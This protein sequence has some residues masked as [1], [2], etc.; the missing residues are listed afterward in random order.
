ME[1]SGSYE[2]LGSCEIAGVPLRKLK[3]RRT[4]II[5]Y[6]AQVEGPLVNG[7][8]CLATEAHDHDGLPHTLEHLIFLGSEDYPYKGV[9]DQL[10]NRCLASGT[11][12]WTD[13]DHTVYTMTNAGSEGF[14][15]LMPVYLEHILYPTLTDSGFITEVHHINGEGEDA[16]V[17]YCEMQAR[18]N[19]AEERTLFHLLQAMY[20][21][22]CGYKSETGGRL[23]NLRTSCSNERV[24]AYHKQYYRPDNLALIITGQLEPDD[25]FVALAPFE[26]KVLHKGPLPPMERPWQSPV[27]PLLSSVCEV[28]PFPSD[29]ER[30]G[31]VIMAWRGP[32]A[33]DRYLY[34]AIVSLVEY[35]HSTSVAPLQQELVYISEPYCSEMELLLQ[36]NAEVCLGLEFHGVPLQMLPQIKDK[37][38][39]I[40]SSIA[41]GKIP[42]DMDRLR[43]ILVKQIRGFLNKMEEDPH[44]FVAFQAIGD[45]LFGQTAQDLVAYIDQTT[46]FRKLMGEPESFWLNLLTHYFIKSPYVAIL[47]TPSTSLA[48][49]MAQEEKDRITKQKEWLGE[50]GLAQKKGELEEAVRQ[51]EV[52]PPV[53][54]V[55]SFPVPGIESIRFHPLLAH[56][57]CS[58]TDATLSQ[59]LPV[60]HLPFFFEVHHIHSSLVKLTAV[61][62]TLAVPTE[63][64]PYIPLYLEL[65]FDSSVQRSGVI[66]SHEIRVKEIAEHTVSTSASLGQKGKK[67]Q[68]GVFPE[69]AFVTIK[70]EPSEY[71]KG[72]QYL[73]EAMYGLQFTRDR[74]TVVVNKL[75]NYITKVKRM[76]NEAVNMVH[77]SIVF[78]RE[79]MCNFCSAITQEK[80][81]ENIHLCLKDCTAA[82]K[83]IED[84]RNVQNALVSPSNI[85]VFVA[86]NVHTLAHPNPS[87][88]W[89]KFVPN[90]ILEGP[91][92][93]QPPSVSLPVAL[94]QDGCCGRSILT[95]LGSVESSYLVQSAP[96]IR[97]PHHS[98]LPSILVLIE[99]L[100]ALE[101]PMWRQI[102]GMGLSYGYRLECKPEDGL[103]YFRLLRSSHVMQ[104]YEAAKK[105]VDDFVKGTTPLNPAQ[106]EA[107]ISGT[108]FFIVDLQQSLND[109][110]DQAIL[111]SLKALNI[112][113]SQNLLS[114]VAKVTS[115]DLTRVGRL[116]FSALFDP[117]VACCAVLC[118]TSKA[119]DVKLGFERLGFGHTFNVTYDLGELCCL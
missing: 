32:K 18:E 24:K 65:L 44:T 56:G 57:N 112:T 99:Y 118:N 39:N 20:P 60:H 88:P 34:S 11:N 80:F 108:I 52:P 45:F 26:D 83:I 19:T 85:R 30:D 38:L 117:S 63:L 91:H 107:A 58:T 87:D 73:Q 72:V 13:V 33:V 86:M 71:V 110:A 81:L 25:V 29:D 76:G 66:I 79:S 47:G 7:Y 84:M 48:E 53:N 82:N 103:L 115:E 77:S 14:L 69:V 28:V 42:F 10:A 102:R 51:N 70:V 89:L 1:G 49:T 106:L 62:D 90:S 4:G 68:F 95:G 93:I 12:A 40:L 100:G 23:H 41:G 16:G 109:L 92:T 113:F 43:S 59:K 114:A 46:H 97:L 105:I 61:L 35:L 74:L 2:T 15:S 98:D 94:L 27:P 67:F 78:K 17:V 64:R 104:A 37:V 111:T 54:I 3:S 50:A 36:E 21:G 22:N 5:V 8:F 6:L 9:L 55:A 75:L 31:M 116:Y 96:C 101:G 119:E